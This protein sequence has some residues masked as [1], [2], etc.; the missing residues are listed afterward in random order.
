M[1]KLQVATTKTYKK[2]RIAYYPGRT[3]NQYRANVIALGSAPPVGPPYNALVNLDPLRPLSPE[4]AVRF[5][6]ARVRSTPARSM[7][8]PM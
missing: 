7:A 4:I 5:G 6:S 1:T 8:W 2:C 3:V